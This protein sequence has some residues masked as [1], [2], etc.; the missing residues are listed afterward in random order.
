[1]DYKQALFCMEATGL[2]CYTLTQFLSANTIDTWVEH[3]ARIKRATALDRGKNDKVDSKR[4]A[5]YCSKNLDRLQLWKPTDSTVDKLKHLATLR[6]RLVETQK[7]L[8][9]PIQEF[10][11]SGNPEMAKLLSKTIKKSVEAIEKDLK[12]L[13]AKIKELMEADANL[14]QVF[15]NATSVVGIGFVTAINLIV[16]TNGF[17]MLG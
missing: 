15:R 3:A 9:V 13:E 2:Y 17:T 11:E 16:H 5:L 1:M 12:G 14:K 10:E 4:I 8:L 6:E 7:R